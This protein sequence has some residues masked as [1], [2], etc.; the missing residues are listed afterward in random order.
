LE[1]SGRLQMEEVSFERLELIHG[2]AHMIA[3]IPTAQVDDP[4]IALQLRLAGVPVLMST[5]AVRGLSEK[6]K[7][8]LAAA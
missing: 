4:D 1:L 6:Q 5:K 2:S 3:K 7:K 8:A